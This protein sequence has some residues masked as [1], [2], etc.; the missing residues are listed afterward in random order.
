MTTLR[1]D[2]QI[3]MPVAG[4][5]VEITIAMPVINVL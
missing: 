5:G 3:T 2:T 4:F 1:Y